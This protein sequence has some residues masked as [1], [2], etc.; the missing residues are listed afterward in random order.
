MVNQTSLYFTPEVYNSKSFLIT[1]DMEDVNACKQLY[2]ENCRDYADGLEELV[3]LIKPNYVV[4][5]NAN[6][7][8]RLYCEIIDVLKNYLSS[9]K[10]L[11][12]CVLK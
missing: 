2:A 8:L 3:Q 7:A 5:S 9:G 4:P 1:V 10:A 11:E 12:T 6:D